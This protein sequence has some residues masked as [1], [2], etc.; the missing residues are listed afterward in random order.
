MGRFTVTFAYAT[1]NTIPSA[2][3]YRKTFGCAYA[4]DTKRQVVC[5]RT[6]SVEQTIL[7]RTFGTRLVLFVILGRD[8]L[9]D[10]NNIAWFNA[11]LQAPYR[12]AVFGNFLDTANSANANLC[13]CNPD[14]DETQITI[15]NDLENGLTLLSD[16]VY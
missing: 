8:V 2:G 16:Q 9:S 7:R 10:S 6:M 12:W 15:I 14:S 3:S 1:T 13:L 4:D 5:N 11:F